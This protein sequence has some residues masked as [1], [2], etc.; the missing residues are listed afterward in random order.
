MNLLNFCSGPGEGR[1][2]GETGGRGNGEERDNSGE[3]G[4]EGKGRE[5]KRRRGNGQTRAVNTNISVQWKLV[6]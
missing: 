4:G 2:M 5:G 6:Q 3:K 1:T